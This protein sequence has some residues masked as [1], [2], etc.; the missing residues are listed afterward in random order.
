MMEYEGTR[1]KQ[2]FLLA[3][4]GTMSDFA[5]RLDK[6]GDIRIGK[7]RVLLDT[8]LDHYKA[9]TPVE[10]IIRAYDTLNPADVFEA[11]AY[12]LRHKEE[13]EAY[14]QRREAEA[15]ILWKQIEAEQPSKEALKKQIKE[16][17]SKRL[18]DNAAPCD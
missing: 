2:G 16:R 13:V 12:Y 6:H 10:E 18:A 15:Q 8:I 3:G 9:G 4:A 5:L 14:F 7:S 11:I 17:W 1:W